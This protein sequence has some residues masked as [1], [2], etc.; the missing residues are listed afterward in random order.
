MSYT[1]HGLELTRVT[2]VDH[3]CSPIYDRYVKPY[4]EMLSYNTEYSGITA[5]NLEGVTTTL[6]DVQEYILNTF[7]ADTIFVGHSL[8]S[9][10]IALRLIHENVVDTSLIF[11]HPKGLNYKFALRTLAKKKLGITIQSGGHDS[12][13]DASTCMSIILQRIGM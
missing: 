4:G 9:D 13:E 2:I 8:Q 10:F 6:A 3:D 5:N 7:S 1:V 12:I 11:N